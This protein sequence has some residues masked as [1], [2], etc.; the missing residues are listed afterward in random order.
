MY[1]KLAIT[2]VE[3]CA[4]AFPIKFDVD[5]GWPLILEKGY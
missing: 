1:S 5:N 4:F 3:L 2:T